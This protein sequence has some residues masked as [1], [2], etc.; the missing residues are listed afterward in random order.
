[1]GAVLLAAGVQIKTLSLKFFNLN[2]SQ[3][4]ICKI[5]L[6]N[7]L[8]NSS[9]QLANNSLG[10]GLMLNVIF[11]NI[12]NSVDSQNGWVLRSLISTSKLHE[13]ALFIFFRVGN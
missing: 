7:T 11:K 4:L 3:L 9:T 12:F 2:V 8:S 13:V 6:L 1:M 10:H 5:I